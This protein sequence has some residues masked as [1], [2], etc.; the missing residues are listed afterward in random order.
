MRYKSMSE[1]RAANAA[2]GHYFFS[3]DTMR[4]FES[5]IEGGPYGGR[6]FV[7]SEQPPH[8]PRVFTV[9]EALANGRIRTVGE[10]GP[11]FGDRYATVAEAIAVARALGREAE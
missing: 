9:R 3:R 4:A 5:K 1:I 7:T 8:G 10:E 6:F 11:E 2:A